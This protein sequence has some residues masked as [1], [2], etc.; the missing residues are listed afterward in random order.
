MSSQLT[1]S[2]L[3]LLALV[4][5]ASIV[6]SLIY[7]GF[8]FLEIRSQIAALTISYFVIGFALFATLIFTVLLSDFSVIFW[9]VPLLVIALLSGFFHQKSS[10]VSIVFF[11]DF[12]LMFAVTLLSFIANLILLNVVN[13]STDKFFPLWTDNEF[14]TYLFGTLVSAQPITPPFLVWVWQNIQLK[15]GTDK[16]LES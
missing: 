7:S 5:V 9:Y 2:V 12:V 10:N 11:V 13:F 14:F 16:H 3:A 15:P 1:Q 8:R 4:L 6:S